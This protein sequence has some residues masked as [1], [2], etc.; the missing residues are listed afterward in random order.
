MQFSLGLRTP[1]LGEGRRESGMVPFERALVSCYR[2][3]IVSFPLSLR[4]SEILPLLFSSSSTPLFP[5]PK[6]PPNFRMFPLD[7]MDCLLATKSEGV[8]LIVCASNQFP[9]FPAYVITI[10]QHHR[11]TNR[12]TTCDRKTALCTKVHSAVKKAIKLHQLD[13]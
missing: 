5:Y 13:P 1:H 2:P 4:V 3:S 12:R 9:T 7:W 11:Q 8:R 6:S 10:H